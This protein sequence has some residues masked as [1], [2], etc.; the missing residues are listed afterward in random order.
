MIFQQF[1]LIILQKITLVRITQQIPRRLY[2]RHKGVYYKTTRAFLTESEEKVNPCP[3]EFC[4]LYFLSFEAGI[5]NAI[6]SFDEKY[7]YIF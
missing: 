2:L 1:K 6:S 7:L 3:A 5:A 4:L